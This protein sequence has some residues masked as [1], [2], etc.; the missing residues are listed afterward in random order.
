MFFYV[1]ERRRNAASKLKKRRF[2]HAELRSGQRR[3]LAAVVR[4]GKSRQRGTRLRVFRR[5]GRGSREAARRRPSARGRER[6]GNP[7]PENSRAEPAQKGRRSRDR[8]PRR[9]WRRGLW[10]DGER[11]APAP[12]RRERGGPRR[13]MAAQRP[14]ALESPTETE[15][16]GA[17]NGAGGGRAVT[18]QSRLI[19]RRQRP[20]AGGK[21][22]GDPAARQGQRRRA[23]SP[24]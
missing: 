21:G 3:R 6:A 22:A 8:S 13:D 18:R 17:A 1:L 10:S 11:R 15:G 7:P 23:R 19:M 4:W 16:H 9:L 2:V 14:A 24:T 5:Q 12:W 20:T